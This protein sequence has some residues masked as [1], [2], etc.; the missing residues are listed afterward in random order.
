MATKSKTTTI[1][2]DPSKVE[3]AYTAHEVAELTSLHPSAVY[4]LMQ[5]GRIRSVPMG[6]RRRVI[7][8]AEVRRILAEGIE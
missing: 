3:R 7:P 8:A 2:E 1:D 4:R 6:D 5:S